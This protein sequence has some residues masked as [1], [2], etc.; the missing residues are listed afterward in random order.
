MASLSIAFPSPSPMD[1]P[2]C[3]ACATG[4]LFR[5]LA[6]AT[7]PSLAR[8]GATLHGSPLENGPGDQSLWA[9]AYEQGPWLI[10]T[11]PSQGS[12]VARRN[13]VA[14]RTSPTP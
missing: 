2:S 13:S 12:S 9:P 8:L 10:P 4:L 7:F 6:S 5:A 14:G 11:G 3:S 1:A